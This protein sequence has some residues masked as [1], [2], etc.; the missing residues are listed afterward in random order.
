MKPEV[1]PDDNTE[2]GSNTI[3]RYVM[4]GVETG[5]RGIP[6]LAGLARKDG[7]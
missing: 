5:H 1:I 7:V 2:R 3:T 6:G 4:R